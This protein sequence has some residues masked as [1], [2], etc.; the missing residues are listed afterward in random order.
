[1]PA[2]RL[3]VLCVTAAAAVHLGSVVASWNKPIV[4]EFIGFSQMA[5]AIVETGRPLVRLNPD[6]VL[7]ADTVHPPTYPYLL[8]LAFK[9]LGERTRS[10]VLLNLACLG[11][12]LVL[13]ALITRE[14]SPHPGAVAAIASSLLLV[15]PFMIQGSLFTAIDTSILLPAMLAYSWWFLRAV[16][17]MTPRRLGLLALLFGLALWTK[18][19]TPL[20]LPAATLGFYL[21]RG[22]VRRGLRVSAVVAAG[23][24]LFFLVTYYAVARWA[25]LTPL[26]A[27]EIAWVQGSGEIGKNLAG[28]LRDILPTVKTDLIWF[29]P[30][31]LAL[32]GLA[33]ARR[34]REYARERR[35]AKIDFLLL[36]AALVY[37][38]YTLI[39]P[40][41]GIPRWKIVMIPPLALAIGAMLAGGTERTTAGAPAGGWVLAA[42]LVALYYWAQPEMI[43]SATL[44][45]ATSAPVRKVGLMLLYLLPVAG[46]LGAGL[47]WRGARRLPGTSAALLAV[48]LGLAL[49]TDA[50]HALADGTHAFWGIGQRGFQETIAYLR[51]RAR[52]DEVIFAYYDVAHYA[53]NP[54]YTDHVSVAGRQTVD[55]ERLRQ[56]M[57]RRRVAFWVF[58]D[59]PLRWRRGLHAS[60]EVAAFLQERWVLTAR[61]GD[62]LV[63]ENRER[64]GGAS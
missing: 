57:I 58:E 25:G 56:I 5:R 60:P 47:L 44:L 30:P 42:A 33:F 14:V 41:D 46:A 10:A 16:D 35:A 1:M 29:T 51:E 45:S 38:A 55:V 13:L 8:A 15:H 62:F 26:G 24:V 61:F 21:L 3:L 19:T 53:R 40:S 36:T 11:L 64:R 12:S 20:V 43:A 22:E 39:I 31:F 59:N 27:V 23:G 52:R 54:A 2:R 49:T 34:A 18:F 6:Q 9:V 48:F 7:Y 32:A 63:Y 37:L 50:R 17:A 4:G 28:R